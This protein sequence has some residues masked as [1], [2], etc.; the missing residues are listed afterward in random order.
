MIDI[1]I[2]IALGLYSHV[3]VHFRCTCKVEVARYDQTLRLH[4]VVIVSVHIPSRYAQ[5]N[6]STCTTCMYTLCFERSKIISRTMLMNEQ[7][8]KK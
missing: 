3:T 8:R 1:I 6:V 4:V 5:A 2:I 7:I